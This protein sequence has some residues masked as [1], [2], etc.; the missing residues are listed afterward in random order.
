MDHK[1]HVSGLNILIAVEM[2]FTASKIDETPVRCR[3]RYSISSL[4]A[5]IRRTLLDSGRKVAQLTLLRESMAFTS[6]T[7]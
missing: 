4:A 7:A 6:R 3:L 2:K 1:N 5:L